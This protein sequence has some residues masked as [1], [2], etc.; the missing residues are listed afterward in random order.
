M[1]QKPFPKEKYSIKLTKI[2]Y[3]NITIELHKSRRYDAFMKLMW[4]NFVLLNIWIKLF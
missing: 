4:I 3:R 2:N 1:P